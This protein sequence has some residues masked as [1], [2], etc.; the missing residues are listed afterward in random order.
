MLVD[1]CP[2]VPT[3]FAFPYLKAQASSNILYCSVILGVHFDLQ[4]CPQIQMI[5]AQIIVLV[6]LDVTS[7]PTNW[8]LT[9]DLSNPCNKT[10]LRIVRMGNVTI[11][12]PI[13]QCMY[14]VTSFA[15][16][17]NHIAQAH[18]PV[19]VFVFLFLLCIG[20]NPMAPAIMNVESDKKA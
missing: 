14:T 15:I 3:Q 18:A 20:M 16:V 5:R 2:D 6:T 17:L 13:C 7:F 9:H 4:Q 1:R 12:C 19:V 8:A 10:V 11:G